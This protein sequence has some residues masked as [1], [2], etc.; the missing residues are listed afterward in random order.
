[1]ARPFEVRLPLEQA[2]V[3]EVLFALELLDAVTLERVARGVTV[4]AVGLTGTPI[5]NR[6]DLFVW[7]KEPIANFRKLLIEPGTRPFERMEI[8]AA[9]V[10]MPLHTVEL[11][12]LGSYPFT[13]GITAIRGSLYEKKV[14]GGKTPVPVRGATIRLEWQDDGGIF[15]PGTGTAVT[16]EAGDF[17]AIL[18]FAPRE[19]PRL[20][21]GALFVRLFAKRGGGPE[22][23]QELKNPQPLQGR[24]TDRTFAWDELK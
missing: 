10:K 1:M 4:T 5:V 17:T 7:L 8:P 2:Y 15:Q 9:Q 24:V 16:N 6:G 13:P 21:K 12:P 11:R 14:T 18:R 22:R 3:R 20:D 23:S 19:E